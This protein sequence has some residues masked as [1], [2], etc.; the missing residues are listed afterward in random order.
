MFSLPFSIY[1]ALRL[2]LSHSCLHKHTTSNT[3]HTFTHRVDSLQGMKNSVKDMVSVL[4]SLNSKNFADFYRWL[5]DFY[6]GSNAD[7]R[8]T[9]GTCC[10][11][12]VGV[13]VCSA[14]FVLVSR[15]S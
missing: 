14:C 6:R 2:C 4:A 11:C 9:L 8:K 12:R 5:F 10:V 7:D 3:I 13:L 15:I 1:L